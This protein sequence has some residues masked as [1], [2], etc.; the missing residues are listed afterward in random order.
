MTVES[1]AIHQ[2]PIVR[3]A[4]LLSAVLAAAPAAAQS[5]PDSAK[6]PA[7]PAPATSGYGAWF[8]SIPDMSG[9]GEGVLLS[10]VS[11]GSPAEKAGVK[12]GDQLLKLAGK[13]IADLMAMTEVLR[14]KQPGDTI[15]VVLLREGQQK[16]LSVVL[17]KRP[18]S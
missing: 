10:G 4:L 3:H 18:G 7:R 17:G 8:G 1:R 16:R 11:A 5:R 13:E 12:A 9:G 6:A 2:E 14:A 15:E